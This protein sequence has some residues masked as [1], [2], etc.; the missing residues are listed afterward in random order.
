MNGSYNQ[1]NAEVLYSKEDIPVVDK[2]DVEYFKALALKN[3]RKRVRLCSHSSPTDVL[4]EMFIVHGKDEYVRPHK[5]PGKSESIHVIE[6]QVDV[7]LFA[8]DGRIQQVIKMG[9]YNS[10]KIFFYRLDEPIFHTLIIR[11]EILVFS[12]VTNGP[13]NRDMTQFASWAPLDTEYS[14]VI[15]Y[16]SDLRERLVNC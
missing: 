15:I 13:F 1:I 7:V 3:D 12:E 10:G 14:D 4:H 2:L 5:H 11:S 9:D 8:D 6:G 16:I